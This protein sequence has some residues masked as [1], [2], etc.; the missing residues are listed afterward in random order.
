MNAQD[1]RRLLIRVGT[2]VVLVCS[3]LV[4]AGVFPTEPTVYDTVYATAAFRCPYPDSRFPAQVIRSGNQIVVEVVSFGTICFTQN[5][6]ILNYSFRVGQLE[7][8]DYTMQVKVR[9]PA[10]VAPGNGVYSAVSLVRNFSVKSGFPPRALGEW[11]DDFGAAA[12]TVSPLDEA[13]YLVFWNTFDSA[14]RPFWLR[15]EMTANGNQLSGPIELVQG[16]DIRGQNGRPITRG[17]FGTL[18]LINDDCGVLLARWN[19]PQNNISRGEIRLHKR[20]SP[21]GTQAC[22]PPESGSLVQSGG[23]AP[24]AAV[25]F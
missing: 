9:F 24:K 1:L 15:S 13:N 22:E 14:G 25:N 10:N 20:S 4:R 16:G 8:G 7:A 6:D 17:N 19:T 12:L 2:T 11:T 18:Q 21:A 23:S 3:G 5:T